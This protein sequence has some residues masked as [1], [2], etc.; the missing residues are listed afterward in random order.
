MVTPSEK[1]W[2]D[3][4][5]VNWDEASVHVLTHTLHYGLGAFEGIRCYRGK[6]GSMIFRLQEHVD[7]LFE[8]AH[9]VMMNVPYSRKDVF[10]AIVETVRINKL[11][12]CYIRPLL[13][14]GYGEMGL[15]PGEQSRQAGDCRLAVG[16]L[17][18]RG[19]PGAWNPG[20][21]F[22]VYPPPRERLHAPRKSLRVLRE[23][24]FGQV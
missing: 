11:D 20:Q 18:G 4:S 21:G 3:G 14:V 6:G 15:Y 2:M 8:S 19:C 13:Y 1:I 10:E 24:H 5:F 16:H 23:F 17:S 7:R 12:S 22:I 9:I